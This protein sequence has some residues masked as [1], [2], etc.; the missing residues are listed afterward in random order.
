MIRK[1]F[2]FIGLI[3]SCSA[4]KK[5]QEEYAMFNVGYFTIYPSAVIGQNYS[6][7]TTQTGLRTNYYQREKNIIPKNIKY[8]FTVN[9]KNIEFP[10]SEYHQ[11]HTKAQAHGHLDCPMVVFG[12]HA[13]DTSLKI[14]ANTQANKALT[15]ISFK[16][17]FSPVLQEIKRQGY[18]QFGEDVIYKDELQDIALLTNIPQGMILNQPIEGTQQYLLEATDQE[19]I[20]QLTLQI[21]NRKEF[22][23]NQWKPSGRANYFYPELLSNVTILERNYQLAIDYVNDYFHHSAWATQSQTI[24]EES[25]MT[26]ATMLALGILD[27]ETVKTNL[28][29]QITQN[30]ITNYD[31]HFGGWPISSE[32]VLWGISAWQLYLVTGDREWLE[33]IY[34]ILQETVEQDIITL[35][36]HHTGLIKGANIGVGASLSNYPKWMQPTDIFNSQHLSTNTIHYQLFSIL[37]QASDLLG[38][39]S[40]R[41]RKYQQQLKL[42]INKNLWN[43]NVG[44]YSSYVYGPSNLYKFNRIDYFGE[45]MTTLNGITSKRQAKLLYQNVPLAPF[46]IPA[47][48]PLA[49]NISDDQAHILPLI[50]T[51]WIWGASENSN[52]E[53][54]RFGIGSLLRA[55]SL[56]LQTPASV[57]ASTGTINYINATPEEK[58]WSACA[59]LGLYYRVLMGMDFRESGL[60]F[61][62]KIP[63]SFG[64]ELHLKNFKYRNSLLDIQI[65]GHG[66]HIKSFSIDNVAKSTHSIPNNI[67]GK[68]QV[69]IVM[70]NTP[71][72]ASEVDLLPM[73]KMLKSPMAKIDGNTLHW[74]QQKNAIAYNVLR[75]GLPYAYVADEHNFKLIP[76]DHA[77]YSVQGI[78]SLGFTSYIS[79]PLLPESNTLL[80]PASN[81]TYHKSADVKGLKPIGY[82]TLKGEDRSMVNFQIN[83]KHEGNYFIDFHYSNGQQPD[84]AQGACVSRSLSISGIYQGVV[85]MPSRGK[86]E[87]SNWGYSNKT[88]IRLPKGRSTISLSLESF[89]DGWRQENNKAL[90]DYMRITAE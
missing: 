60:H 57:N 53:A 41:Y 35:M 5:T 66:Q 43:E 55:N 82:F 89:N 85:V 72:P 9:G 3:L 79:K 65:S 33:F 42:A 74:D 68:H 18:C 22:T 77:Q 21:R 51:L 28:T 63:G 17:D 20:Y 83:L 56:S 31:K 64:S 44:Y 69:K 32:H 48:C 13:P 80:V 26:F 71:W 1:L 7:K 81:V 34:P 29:A 86:G 27:P 54:A 11:Y 84:K 75:N 88:L 12:K 47:Y 73:V 30:R 24:N 67:K 59:T 10:S 37:A 40:D 19:G 62:P 8:T 70:T 45:A 61:A 76:N 36:D 25:N 15:A 46:G 50:Q 39:E 6:A 2:L 23:A 58:L 78:D 14:K 87:W 16:L 4:C 38:K 52:E 49:N 90:I